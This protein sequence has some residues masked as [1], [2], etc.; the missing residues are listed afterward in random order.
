MSQFHFT[1][2]DYLELMH[3][4]VPRYAEL[5]DE[6]ARATEGQVETILELGTGTGETARR[7]LAL[8]PG[9]H[10]VGIDES[11][12]MLAAADIPGA[13][14]RVGRI[15]DPLPEGPFDLVFSCLAVHHLDADGKR[16]LFR[17]VAAVTHT[18]VLAD[19]IVPKDPAEAVTPLTPGFDLPDRLEAVTGWLQQAGFHVEWT[20]V[21][22]DLAVLRCR[23]R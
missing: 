10:L 19:V 18:F 9:A 1:P 5:Q 6:T 2:D 7:V 3:E 20:W 4:E 13:D 16:D 21:R 8:H 17:R 12:K 22:G 11:A 14:L 23:T 15:E